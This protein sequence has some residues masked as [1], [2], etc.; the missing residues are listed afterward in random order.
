[1][2]QNSITIEE[3]N[4]FLSRGGDRAAKVISYLGKGQGFINVLSSD[5]GAEILSDLSGMMDERFDRIVNETATEKDIAEFRALKMIA[6]RWKDKIDK[7]YNI[8]EEVKKHA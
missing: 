2:H 6:G 5:I 3:V 4:A 1:M 8:I 7:H